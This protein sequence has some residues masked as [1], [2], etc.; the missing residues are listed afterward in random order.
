LP[1]VSFT[2]KRII[3]MSKG[4][5]DLILTIKNISKS[6]GSLVAVDDVH[7]D[8][9]HRE[10]HAV[11]GENG[12]GK[13]TLMN[14]LGGIIKRDAGEIIYK[15]EH[16]EFASPMDS[17]KAGVAVIHQELSMLPDLNVIENLF[18]GH[19]ESR[20]GFVLWKTLEKKAT[21]LLAKVGLSI[22][23]YTQVSEL[24]ISD[25]QLVEIAKAL[26][27]NAS[28]IIMDEPNSS[29]TKSETAQLFRVIHDL[30]KGGVSI[31]YVSHKIDEVLAISDRISVLRD[32]HYIGT[33][34]RKEATV[35]KVIRMMVG[36]ELD[37]GNLYDNRP[38][39]EIV[40]DVRGISGAQFKDISFDVRKGE[41]VGLSG[42]VGAGRTEVANAIFGLTPVSEGQI[43][44]YQ[45]RVQFKSPIEAIKNGIAMVPEDR[46]ELSLFSQL[47]I[48]LN[49]SITQLS[50]KSNS[51]IINPAKVKALINRFKDLLK[52][53]M[54]SEDY[55]VSSLSGG[56]QQKV[57]LSRWLAT[58]PKLLILDEPTHGIDVGT[59]AEIY[60]L[61]HKLTAEGISIILISSELPEIILMSDRV[62]VL[63][64]G[65]I[66]GILNR[67]ELTEDI[68]MT[69]AT[70]GVK[71]GNRV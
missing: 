66:T 30:K 47:S 60:K 71:A 41:I 24:S 51:S 28:L 10:V 34:K 21:E 29:L 69:Y 8:L 63:H 62:V 14:I 4:S 65:R 48:G 18:M 52:I 61:M 70:N 44:W 37:S 54:V 68:I 23:P 58:D 25:R 19:M 7:L 49:M 2:Y 45:K 20:F 5:N 16:V 32:G 67:D 27:L 38:K 50:R 40:L 46:K 55:P 15:G 9:H 33:L 22:D 57:V 35:E 36:R 42:L 39:G 59:K 17:I 1:P 11:V 6:Y 3:D 13:S 43:F 26:G 64:E 31:L 12:A 53:K 56:N